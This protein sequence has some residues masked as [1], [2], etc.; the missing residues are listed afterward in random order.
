AGRSQGLSGRQH[1]QSITC[2]S[3]AIDGSAIPA[4]VDGHYVGTGNGVTQKCTE[5][6]LIF[7]GRGGVTTQHTFED[8]VGDG[9]Q[10]LS[11]GLLLATAIGD[12]AKYQGVFST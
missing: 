10:T 12:V 3:I 8:K 2:G 1:D 6:H 5:I 9:V 11:I 7:V 4:T